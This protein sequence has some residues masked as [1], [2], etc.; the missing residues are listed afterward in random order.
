MKRTRV[1]LIWIVGISFI[2]VGVLKYFSLEPELKSVFERANYPTWFYYV[3]GTIEFMGGI[4][5]LMT[6][7]TSKRLGSILIGLIMMGALVTR[8]LL[9]EPPRRFVLPA[10]VLI[11]ALII[12]FDFESKKK[13]AK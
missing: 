5:L 9:D 7:S 10:I 6:A 1:V 4:L 3:I 8:Y 13:G 12:S 11:I 2:A